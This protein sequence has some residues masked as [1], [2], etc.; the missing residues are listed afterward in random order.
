MVLGYEFWQYLED[1]K[2]ELK[3]MSL[4]ELSKIG[5][6]NMLEELR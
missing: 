6:N 1:R 4:A 5:F 3:N 2:K